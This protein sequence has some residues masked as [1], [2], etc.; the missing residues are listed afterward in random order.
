MQ[1]ALPGSLH[2]ARCIV[3]SCGCALTHSYPPQSRHTM[4][5]ALP[6]S[7]HRVIVSLCS[8]VHSV[9]VDSHNYPPQPRHTMQIALPGSLHRV[10]VWLCTHSQLSTTAEVLQHPESLQRLQYHHLHL[11][12][13][14]LILHACVPPECFLLT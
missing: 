5:I 9:Q 11:N 1:I 6:S 2:R 10:I 8:S 7:L 14:I 4:Q 13:Q 12:C 3:S